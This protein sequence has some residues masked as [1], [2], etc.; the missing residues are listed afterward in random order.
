[1]QLP[2]LIVAHI[3]K[4][5]FIRCAFGVRIQEMRITENGTLSKLIYV[6]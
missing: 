2:H 3:L 6:R 5:T 1:M 4:F